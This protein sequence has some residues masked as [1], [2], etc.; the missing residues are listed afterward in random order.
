MFG[1]AFDVCG[2]VQRVYRDIRTEVQEDASSVTDPC[3]GPDLGW[4][5]DYG[6]SPC[7]LDSSQEVMVTRITDYVEAD[8]KSDSSCKPTAPLEFVHAG[9]GFGKSVLARELRRRLEKLFGKGII[10]FAAPS[11]IAAANMGGATCHRA[12]GLRIDGKRGDHGADG[13]KK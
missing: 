8:A 1:S 12:F 6:T 3:I 2:H 11:G 7:S 9:P 13:S 10:C 5:P 4:K